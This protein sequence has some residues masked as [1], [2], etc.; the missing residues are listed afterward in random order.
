MG[1][2]GSDGARK[3]GR[4]LGPRH[5]QR[6]LRHATGG[7]TSF[8]ILAASPGGETM[9]RIA[10]A[11]KHSLSH[12]KAK[13]AAQKVAEDLNERFDLD[14]TW[15]GDCIDFRHAGLTGQLHVLKDEVRLDCQL[16]FLLGAIKPAI[17]HEVH[18]E[19]DKRFGKHK[20]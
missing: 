6:L 14:Y 10:I 8:V 16:S 2:G 7:A 9:A 19:F 11:K 18:K 1:F 12:K 13:E 20:A 5:W 15:N 4:R 17:E 3:G